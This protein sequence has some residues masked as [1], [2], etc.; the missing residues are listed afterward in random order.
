MYI[1]MFLLIY[2]VF[3]GV[4][5]MG[6][7]VLLVFGIYFC[8]FCVVVF[9]AGTGVAYFICCCGIM[10]GVVCVGGYMCCLFFRFWRIFICFSIVFCICFSVVFKLSG[11]VYFDNNAYFF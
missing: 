2:V 3:V 6:V 5:C 1:H 9:C 4:I 10:V 7:V 8:V 11:G